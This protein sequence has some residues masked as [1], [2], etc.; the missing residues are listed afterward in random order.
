MTIIAIAENVPNGHNTCIINNI[1][2]LLIYYRWY[3]QI[4][5]TSHIQA[6]YEEIQI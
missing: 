1:S 5:Y 4:Q 3:S 6:Y 2:N